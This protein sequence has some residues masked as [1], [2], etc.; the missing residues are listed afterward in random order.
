MTTT[1]S[2]VR[3]VLVVEDDYF[4]AQ[5]V[6]RH[7][8]D[9]GLEVVGPC[10][11]VE[12]ALAAIDEARPDAAVVDINLHGDMAYGVADAL[13]ARNIPFVFATGYD[14]TMIPERF[15]DVPRCLKPVILDDLSRALKL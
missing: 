4:I 9:G 7:F 8:A 11:N 3:R 1:L 13:V 15:E 10:N 12:E 5:E 6:A 2:A 14:A